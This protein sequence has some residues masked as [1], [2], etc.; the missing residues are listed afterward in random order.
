MRLL[1][2]LGLLA[3]VSL[4]ALWIAMPDAIQ[5]WTDDGTRSIVAAA[6]AAMIGVSLTSVLVFLYMRLR[7]R[8]L[9]RAA[10][11]MAAGE[12]GVSLGAPAR[13]GGSIGRLARAIDAISSAL[14][15]TTDAA[16]T[17]KLTGVSNR[18]K[19]VADLIDEVER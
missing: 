5:S 10:E 1:A 8:K 6:V 11:R 3:P 13:G 12:L 7:L 19:L 2:G 15:T 14:D 9:V 17:D 4:I 16:T 18:Q